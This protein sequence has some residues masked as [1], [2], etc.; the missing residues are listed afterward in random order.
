MKM[1]V[2]TEEK[3]PEDMELVCRIHDNCRGEN[4]KEAHIFHGMTKKVDPRTAWMR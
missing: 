1:T 3:L 2:V 4:I